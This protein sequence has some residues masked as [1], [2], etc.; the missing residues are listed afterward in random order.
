MNGFTT[1]WEDPLIMRLDRKRTL[2]VQ[3]DPSSASGETSAELLQ[4][5]KPGIDAIE[6]PRGYEL[7]WGGDYESTKEAQAGLFTSLPVAFVVMFII[8]VLMFSSF[9]NALAIWLTIPLALIGVTVGFLLTGIPF[10]FMALIGLLSL[11][12]MLIRNGIV[13]VDEIGQQRQKK[14]ILE[15]IIDASTSRLRPILLTAFTTVLGLAPLLSDAFFQSMA[16]VIMF[17]LG[18]ATVLTLLVLPVIYSC[19]NSDKKKPAVEA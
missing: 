3:A 17:G 13:L 12:G 16:V 19:M 1:E 18:F 8:T 11:S 2:T 15:A 5:I 14:P 9:K 4:R 10:G 6:L 7:E